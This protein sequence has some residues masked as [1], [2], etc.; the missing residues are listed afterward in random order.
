MP[1]TC[2]CD[3]DL[4]DFDEWHYGATND[5]YT[6]MPSF[7]RRKKCSSCGVLIN[8]DAICTKF[9][10]ARATLSDIEERI[11]GDEVPKAPRWLCESCSDIYF[12]LNE[13]GYCVGPYEDLRETLKEYIQ[14]NKEM[15]K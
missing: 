12:N 13:L 10:I 6:I 15:L 9:P 5:D 4:G 8:T 2:N 3:Y 14:M 7:S 11:Y 1:L